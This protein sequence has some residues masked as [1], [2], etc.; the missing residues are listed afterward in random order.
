MS[1]TISESGLRLA[2]PIGALDYGLEPI[3]RDLWRTLPPPGLPLGGTLEFDS[4]GFSLT[5]GRT[6]RLRFRKGA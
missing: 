4:E 6:M 1:A 3:G 2:G 5:T